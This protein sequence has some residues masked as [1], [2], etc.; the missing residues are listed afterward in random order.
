MEDE[1]NLKD[2]D[3]DGKKLRDRDGEEKRKRR[4]VD[5]GNSRSRAMIKTC[6]ASNWKGFKLSRT[7]QPQTMTERG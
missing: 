2:K 1:K 5:D 4:N 7:H 3:D 6:N